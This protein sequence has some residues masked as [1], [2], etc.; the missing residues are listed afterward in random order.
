M[1]YETAKG[2]WFRGMHDNNITVL[3]RHSRNI[4][5]VFLFQGLLGEKSTVSGT[6]LEDYNARQILAA[7][8]KICTHLLNTGE[9]SL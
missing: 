9:G 7:M 8:R 1:N 3:T 2:L 4:H 5:C 6:G